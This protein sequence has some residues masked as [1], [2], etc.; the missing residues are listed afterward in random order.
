MDEKR[1]L[2]IRFQIVNGNI[3]TQMQT[4]KVSQQETLGLLDM[5]KH[6]ILTNLAKQSK[7]VFSGSK[8]DDDGK[9]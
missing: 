5:A 2:I 1:E 6:Q 9:E 3:Q 7:E 8:K 4:K